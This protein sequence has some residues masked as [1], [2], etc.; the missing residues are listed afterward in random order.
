MDSAT[1]RL[2]V[3][4]LVQS[5]M[6]AHC[7]FS[8]DR[9]SMGTIFGVSFSRRVLPCRRLFVE[10]VVMI[11]FSF[12]S[13]ESCSRISRV[14][15]SDTASRIISTSLSMPNTFLL[16]FSGIPVFLSKILISAPAF[17]NQF[18]NAAHIFPCPPMIATDFPWKEKFVLIFIKFI[19]Y[20][21]SLAILSL[22]TWILSKHILFENMPC[23][24]V[25]P[26]T[27]GRLA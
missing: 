12:S 13:G 14:T 26:N 17:C 15:I 1:Q 6:I 2:N 18:A 19:C 10:L 24:S 20:L 4:D 23:K 9:V 8:P 3:H 27:T 11:G 16:S 25:Q 22:R 5:I 21:D 7:I